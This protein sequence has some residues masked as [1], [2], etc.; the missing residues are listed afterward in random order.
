MSF[1]YLLVISYAALVCG[2]ASL[3][4]SKDE[5]SLNKTAETSKPEIIKVFACSD[6]CHGPREKYLVNVYKGINNA[7]DCKRVGGIPYVYMGWGKH[8]I[9][10]VK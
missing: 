4:Q 6:Y 8:F 7:S 3:T 2:C 10:K 9:C 1:R 5:G